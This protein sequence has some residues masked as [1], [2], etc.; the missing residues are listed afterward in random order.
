MAN[1]APLSPNIYLPAPSELNARESAVWRDTVESMPSDWFGGDNVPMLVE[2]CRAVVMSDLLTG[3]VQAAFDSHDDKVMADM[4]RLRDMES[5]RVASLA[6]KLRLTNQ[7]R[8]TPKAAATATKG[9]GKGNVW[10]FGNK[11]A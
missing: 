5:K 8:Y 11:S 10:Q 9:A 4:L 6:T 1:V 3:R 7:S 2:Y